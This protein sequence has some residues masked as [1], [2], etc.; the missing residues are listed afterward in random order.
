MFDE[1]LIVRDSQLKVKD[2]PS[3]KIKANNLQKPR[4]R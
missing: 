3:L 4:G 2:K 1:I